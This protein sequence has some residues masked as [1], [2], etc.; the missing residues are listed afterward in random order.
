MSL[1][2]FIINPSHLYKLFICDLLVLFVVDVETQGVHPQPQ[3]GSFLVLD[4][5]VVDPV[6][7]QILGYLQ[8]LHHGVLPAVVNHV[9][10]CRT[11]AYKTFMNDVSMESGGTSTFPCV[12]DATPGFFPPTD[13]YSVCAALKPWF[14]QNRGHDSQLNKPFYSVF[15]RPST[16]VAT[17]S[18]SSGIRVHDSLSCSRRV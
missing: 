12:L 10:C 8:V 5:E 18:L 14:Y 1:L 16:F 9:I 11:N 15:T 13:S 17:A 6:H 3:L 2:L 7:L 4:A